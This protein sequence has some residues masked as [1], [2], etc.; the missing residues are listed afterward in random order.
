MTNKLPIIL[1]LYPN[2]RGFGYICL[3][4]PQKLIDWGMM[5]C[6]PLSNGKILKQVAAMLDYFNPELLVMQDPDNRYARQNSR[7]SELIETI[8]DRAEEKSIKVFT[9]TREQVRSVFSSFGATTKHEIASKLL[10]WF[11]ELMPR[12]PKA[13]KLWMNEDYNMGIFDAL[14]L[15]ITHEY[16]TN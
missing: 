4:N 9:Y 5:N 14:S 13:R 2:T 6:R 15:A 1:S 8:K 16:L 7:V 11:P 3:E 12:A 10:Q